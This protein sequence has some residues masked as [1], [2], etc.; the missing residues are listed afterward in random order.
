[1]I[2]V[3][4]NRRQVTHPL[5]LGQEFSQPM[6]TKRLQDGI[7]DSRFSIRRFLAW[8]CNGDSEMC[9]VGQ[10]AGYFAIQIAAIKYQRM[11]VTGSQ[12]V[13]LV[14]RPCCTPYSLALF[15]KT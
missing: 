4:P 2:S 15:G 5:K 13:N 11:N 10:F 9:G 6:I 3:N 1:M 8:R 12:L 14:I 7:N